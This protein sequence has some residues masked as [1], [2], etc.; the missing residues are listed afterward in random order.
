[1]PL[2]EVYVRR[3]PTDGPSYDQ[4]TIALRELRVIIA[5]CLTCSDPN[6]SLEPSHIEVKIREGHELDITDYD[7]EVSIEAM[8]FP[9]R[10]ANHT[11]RSQ[12]VYN[13]LI[14]LLPGCYKNSHVWMK[15]VDADFVDKVVEVP[16]D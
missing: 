1:M 13:R 6:G 16:D 2:A 10:M 11:D 14:A 4:F 8:K 12:R 15:W 7:L 9:S 3:L 5:D